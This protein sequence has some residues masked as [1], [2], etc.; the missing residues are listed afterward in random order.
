MLEIDN[1]HTR[2]ESA[3]NRIKFIG[4]EIPV[5]RLDMNKGLVSLFCF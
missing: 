3:K 2:F 1:L 5:K 4:A